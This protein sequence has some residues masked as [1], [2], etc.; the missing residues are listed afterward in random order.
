MQS[1]RNQI[2]ACN[3]LQGYTFRQVGFVNGITGNRV[4]QI[5]MKVVKESCG[6][7]WGT[8]TKLLRKNKNWLIGLI[9]V[10]IGGK[11]WISSQI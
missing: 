11:T 3:V 1:R 6:P 4:R 7:M 10:D 5:T 9:K 8:D 2:M